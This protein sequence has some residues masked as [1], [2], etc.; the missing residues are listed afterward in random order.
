MIMCF[1]IAS[2]VQLLPKGRIRS[3]TFWGFPLICAATF[4]YFLP[5]IYAVEMPRHQWLQ[6]IWLKSWT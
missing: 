2:G 5:I 4:L 6:Y 3:V 1:V